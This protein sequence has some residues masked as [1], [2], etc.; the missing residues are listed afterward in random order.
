[1]QLTK[2]HMSYNLGIISSN[3]DNT[4]AM[5]DMEVREQN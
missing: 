4:I 1:M 3:L 5:P 2:E